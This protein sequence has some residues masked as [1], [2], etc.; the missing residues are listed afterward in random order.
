MLDRCN[1]ADRDAVRKPPDVIK[2]R[3]DKLDFV[4][5]IFEEALLR[6]VAGWNYDYLQYYGCKIVD[7]DLTTIMK[8]RLLNK[9]RKTRFKYLAISQLSR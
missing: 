9:I 2:L 3:G 6:T 7:L 1:L 4:T 8:P 5:E